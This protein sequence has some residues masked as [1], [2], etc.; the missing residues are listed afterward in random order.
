MALG[1]LGAGGLRVGGKLPPMRPVGRLMLS[2]GLAVL[3]EDPATL[4]LGE[5]APDSFSLA[6]GK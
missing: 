1:R 3:A 2:G 5:P 6:S 4:A